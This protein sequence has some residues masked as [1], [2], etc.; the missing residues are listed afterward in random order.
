[1]SNLVVALY[2]LS[3][4]LGGPLSDAVDAASRQP[5]VTGPVTK[6]TMANVEC[7]EVTAVDG[8][9]VTIK[10]QQPVVPKLAESLRIDLSSGP[11]R[12]P[13]VGC[14]SS[15]CGMCLLN[16]LAKHGQ[17][18]A[19]LQTLSHT[20][21]MRLHYRLHEE[22]GFDGVKGKTQ[23]VGGGSGSRIQKLFSRRRRS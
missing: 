12:R 19:Y 17:K 18:Y 11:T 6:A 3:P 23:R 4:L 9:R 7:F 13:D 16:S 8:R 2:F 5:S 21:R 1:M 15:R 20:E 14:G 10:L 22:S